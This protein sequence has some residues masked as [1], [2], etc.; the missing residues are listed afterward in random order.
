[1]R[2][3]SETAARKAKASAGQ[4]ILR[5]EPA[6]DGQ[7]FVDGVYV[8]TSDAFGNDTG[9]PIALDAGTHVVQILAAG[10]D[11]V[12]TGVGIAAGRAT[13]YRAQMKASA[14]VADAAPGPAASVAARTRMRGYFIP[15]CY[16]GNVPPR[17]ASLPPGCDPDRAVT[18]QP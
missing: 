15:G 16:L 4:L 10:Y 3:G 18:I 6:I 12:Q 11:V 13:T 5:V 14:S 8:G 7:V 9:Q 2:A 17:E 1:M